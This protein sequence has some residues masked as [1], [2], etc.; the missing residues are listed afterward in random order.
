MNND[1]KKQPNYGDRQALRPFV[2]RSPV[3]LPIRSASA[4]NLVLHPSSKLMES[5]SYKSP[6]Q[7]SEMPYL[8]HWLQSGGNLDF[9]VLALCSCVLTVLCHQS[10]VLPREAT[11]TPATQSTEVGFAIRAGLLTKFPKPTA[12]KLRSNDSDDSN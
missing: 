1:R 9:M 2:E 6:P 4:A 7:P 3:M 11:S 12:P 5:L 8:I 10:T